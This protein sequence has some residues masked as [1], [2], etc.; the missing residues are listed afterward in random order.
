MAERADWPYDDS[1][2]HQQVTGDD[3]ADQSRL[4]QSHYVVTFMVIGE[5][6]MG[7]S[8]IICLVSDHPEEKCTLYSPPSKSATAKCGGS[9]DRHDP[10]VAAISRVKLLQRMACFA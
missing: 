2:F 5:R 6:E 1:N 3:T 10:S 7:K 9:S 4:N 8:C